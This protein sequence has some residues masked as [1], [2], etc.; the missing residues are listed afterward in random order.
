MVYLGNK[1]FNVISHESF[2]NG[3]IFV[4][5]RYI[6]LPNTHKISVLTNFNDL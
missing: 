2:F 4:L 3:T 6:V 5:L 1:D